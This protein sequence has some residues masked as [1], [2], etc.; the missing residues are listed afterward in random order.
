MNIKFTNVMITYLQFKILLIHK[1]KTFKVL[2]LALIGFNLKILILEN[3]I[4]WIINF[5]FYVLFYVL[6]K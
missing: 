5:L 3:F 6:I 2:W 1:R 4:K